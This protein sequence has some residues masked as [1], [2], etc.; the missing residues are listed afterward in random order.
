MGK[1]IRIAY[2]CDGLAECSDKVGCFRHAKTLMDIC[3]HTTDPKHAANGAVEDPSLYPERFHEIDPFGEEEF[4]YW[5]GDIDI[6]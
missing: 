6:P 4:R 3:T 1:N 5:E 2:I